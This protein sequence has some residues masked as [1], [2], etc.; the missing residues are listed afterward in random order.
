MAAWIQRKTHRLLDLTSF[1][2]I[3]QLNTFEGRLFRLQ[4][5]NVHKIQHVGYAWATKPTRDWIRNEVAKS[6]QIS[7]ADALFWFVPWDPA[8][9]A[10]KIS[11]DREL[12]QMTPSKRFLYSSVVAERFMSFSE[13]EFR[14]IVW[15]DSLRKYA[16]P[17]HSWG[18][19][20]W[21]EKEDVKECFSGHQ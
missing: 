21:S 14:F 15:F 8:K 19:R 12:D 16:S 4:F 18:G 6:G 1:I 13:Q 9:N 2:R 5:A 17:A 20:I 10:W 3:L 11:P 7:E